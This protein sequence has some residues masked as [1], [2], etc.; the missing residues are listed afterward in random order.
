MQ[1]STLLSAI[2][3]VVDLRKSRSEGLKDAEDNR[4]NN[5]SCIYFDKIN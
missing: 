3:T 2:K 1:V 5:I 4:Y